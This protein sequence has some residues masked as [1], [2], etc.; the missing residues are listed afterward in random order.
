MVIR[1][2]QDGIQHY[3][4]LATGNYNNLTA[5]LYADLGYFTCDKVLGKDITVLFNGLTGYSEKENYRKLL[6]APGKMRRELI[7]RIDREIQIHQ[8]HGKGYL[9]FKMNSLVDSYCIQALYRASQAGVKIDLQVR[10]ICCLRPGI[11]GISENITVTSI[12]GRF[13]EHTRIYYFRN[14]GEDEILIGSADMMPRNLDRRV[15]IVFPLEDPTLKI[16]LRDQ[17]LKTHLQDNLKAKYKNPDGTYQKIIPSEKDNPLNSQE[18]LIEHRG[19]WH[20]AE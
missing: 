15:E 8:Q 20:H 6:V 2:E 7:A 12:V 3:I 11:P 5:R 17:I 9:A 4:H 18:W 1:Q 16:S 13:L 14:G 19:I 10:G